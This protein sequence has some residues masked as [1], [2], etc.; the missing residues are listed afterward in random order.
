LPDWLFPV[1]GAAAALA[2]GRGLTYVAEIRRRKRV[3][4]TSE[5]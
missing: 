5:R 1:V 3:D 2:L 4:L